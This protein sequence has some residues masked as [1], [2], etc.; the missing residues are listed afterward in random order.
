M[1]TKTKN[2]RQSLLRFDNGE[3]ELKDPRTRKT[4]SSIPPAEEDPSEKAATNKQ[5]EEYDRTV[6]ACKEKGLKLCKRTGYYEL[7]RDGKL[8]SQKLF[9]LSDVRFFITHFNKF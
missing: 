2:A 3:F 1:A 8:V 6:A 9:T 7:T 4:R 5:K